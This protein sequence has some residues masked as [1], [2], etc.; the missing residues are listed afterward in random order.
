[1][2]TLQQLATPSLILDLDVLERNVARMAARARR[3]GVALRPHWKTHKCADV[4][5]LQ[6]AA[7]AV[8]GTVSTLEEARFFA[9]T[10][11]RDLTWAY[12]FPAHRIA[13]AVA[14][15]DDGVTLRLCI[16]GE[17][18]LDALARAGRR[19]RIL[20]E[21]DT[22]YG[23]TGVADHDRA[24]A[25]AR[26]IAES[27]HLVF[28]GLLSHCGHAYHAPSAA[29]IREVAESDRVAMVALAHRLR[30]AGIEVPTV[31]VGSTPSMS[32]V[33]DL[34]GV[35]EARPGNYVFY[36]DTQRRLG[37]CG[38]E[39]CAVTVLT[40]VISSQPGAR[41]S[42]VD[43]G[44]LALSKDPGPE[45]GTTMG[46]ILRDDGALDP[47]LRVAAVSQEHGHLSRPVPVGTLLRI[48]PNHACLAVAC[49]DEYV[50]VRGRDVVGQ[51]KIHRS[52]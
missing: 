26:H 10:G 23:R 16:D 48:L 35:D 27:E 50:V 47:E 14:L 7:G 17:A 45:P 52:R 31:S 38:V 5:A 49:F 4:A 15:A 29:A 25:F 18:A 34:D 20:L 22:G 2:T 44:A 28:E 24:V 1:M 3:L 36:D 30:V 46:E 19:F 21:I 32:L 9:H 33:E 37:A 12:P 8:G 43:A 39:D 42:V 51:W 11:H 6:I 41:H 13:E 40:R